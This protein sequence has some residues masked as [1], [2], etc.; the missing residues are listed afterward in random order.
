[1]VYIAS[2]CRELVQQDTVE[3]TDGC[4]AEGLSAMSVYVGQQTNIPESWDAAEECY[5]DDE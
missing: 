4:G 5:E 1:M 3:G 2:C